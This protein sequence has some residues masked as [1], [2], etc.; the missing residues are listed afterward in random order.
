VDVPRQ[1]PAA[2]AWINTGAILARIDFALLVASGRVPGAWT[3]GKAVA[4]LPHGA[5]VV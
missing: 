2:A 4:S 3:E 5:Q 1:R